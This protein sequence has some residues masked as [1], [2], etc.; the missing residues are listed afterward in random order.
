MSTYLVT[1]ANRGLGL[2]FITQLA[3]NPK[4]T[5]FATVRSED[6]VA[7]IE[8]V[9]SNVKPIV[10]EMNADLEEF[11]K[12]F[13]VFEKEAPEG[14]DIVIHNAGKINKTFTPLLDQPL[15]NFQDLFDVNVLGTVKVYKAI[16]PY[17][18]KGKGLKKF[19]VL[20]S[21]LGTIGGMMQGSNGYGMSKASVNFLI[22]QISLEN[23]QSSDPILKDSISLAICPGMV[24][25]DMPGVAGVDVDNLPPGT[26]ISA[27]ESISKMLKVIH[28]SKKD[29]HD[30]AYYDY[31]GTQLPF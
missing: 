30:G 31:D 4:N 21:G 25:T 8:K 17:L 24:L 5:V 14:I 6:K 28:E 23:N 15:E 3:A 13:K 10:L 22:K 19:T 18:Y 9:G 20:S 11:K 29:T 27:E 7:D 2:E 16:Y 12:A 1:G 26:T